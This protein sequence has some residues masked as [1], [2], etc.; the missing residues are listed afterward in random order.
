MQTPRDDW[1][2]AEDWSY[3]L[4]CGGSIGDSWYDEIVESGR[5]AGSYYSF[6]HEAVLM[7]IPEKRLVVFSHNG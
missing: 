5:T 3:E 4:L 6:K 7:V 2:R 1:H